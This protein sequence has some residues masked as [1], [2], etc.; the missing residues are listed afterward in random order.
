MAV[1]LIREET[2]ADIDAIRAVNRAA[3]VRPNEGRLVDLLRSDGLITVSLVA[4]AEDRVVG[5]VVFS[6]LPIST[7]TGAIDAVALAPVAVVPQHQRR[8][9][10]TALIKGGLRICKERGRAAAFVLGDP[11][12]YARFGFLT[13]PAKS[14]ASKY[15]GPAWQVLELTEGALHAVAGSVTYPAAF[16]EVE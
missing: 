9:V 12:Y 1:M 5:S 8:G 16:E 13:E 3:F 4:V 15:S 14:I 6:H 11:S 7:P 10:G 2:S